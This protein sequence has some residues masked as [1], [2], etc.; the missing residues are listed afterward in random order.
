M[1]KSMGYRK[2]KKLTNWWKKTQIERIQNGNN[3]P[4]TP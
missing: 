4:E 3:T 1:N 2:K